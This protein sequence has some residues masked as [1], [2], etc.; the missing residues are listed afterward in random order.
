MVQHDPDVD[1]WFDRYDNPQKELVLAV[2][3]VMLSADPRVGECIK[4]QAPTFT[5]Q[6]NIASFF[7]KA[8]KHVSLMFHTGASLPDP[9]GILDGDGATSRS[10]KV[11]DHDD[12]TEKTPA[13]HG[14]VRAWIEQRS[15]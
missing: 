3:D 4:W 14:L 9:S 11:L 7:P 15:A 8:K 1:A 10:L 2:R 13:I 6:G 5:Y 12:L